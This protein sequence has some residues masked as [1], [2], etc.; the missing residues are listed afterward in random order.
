M[1]EKHFTLSRTDGAI[2]SAFSMEPQE[3]KTL[4]IESKQAWDALGKVYYGATN[5]EQNS[6]RFRRSLYISKD[7][8][9]GDIFTAKNLRII[10]PGGGL[11][12]KYY[13]LVLGKHI[14]C[15]A[16]K[17]TPVSWELIN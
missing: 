8:R 3:L 11:H 14:K 12:P 7:M 13:D 9:P 17:G 15:A 2:D 6:I 16:N 4:V 1:I 10:R 5:A